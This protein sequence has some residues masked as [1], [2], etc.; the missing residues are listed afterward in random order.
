MF[1]PFLFLIMSFDNFC[2]IVLSFWSLKK[3]PLL[4]TTRYKRTNI[5]MDFDMCGG[6]VVITT[7]GICYLGLR[8]AILV[9]VS[10]H[11]TCHYKI[12]SH[13]HYTLSLI[14]LAWGL[15]NNFIVSS[16]NHSLISVI[17]ILIIQ[18]CIMSIAS[19]FRLFR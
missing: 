19:I 4:L 1:N 5:K 18:C 12:T 6:F 16:P 15:S 17:A 14:W 10:T 13:S 7:L 9:I 3:Y 11:E 8:F 2:L